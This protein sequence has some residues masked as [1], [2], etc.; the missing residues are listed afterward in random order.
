MKKVL[1][2]LLIVCLSYGSSLKYEKSINI[3][4]DNEKKLIWQDNSEVV[5]YLE[6]FHSAKIYCELL[7]L[8]GYI[9]W[10]VPDIKEI[11]DILDV[12]EKRSINQKFQYVNPNIY[13]TKT[14]FKNDDTFTWAVNFQ[15]GK[16]LTVEK[17]IKN[18]IRCVRD[19]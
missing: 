15:D 16:I 10:R 9:D 14:T 11:R 4:T 12:G 2:S 18:H 6:T 1:Y 3:V 17:S 5:E 8:N 13:I 19:I 7:V